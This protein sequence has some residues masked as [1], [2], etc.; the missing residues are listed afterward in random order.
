MYMYVNVLGIHCLYNYT[1]VECYML[2]TCTCIYIYVTQHRDKLPWTTGLVQ[3]Q[4]MPH[5]E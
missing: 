2:C 4:L 1:T 3:W 5:C